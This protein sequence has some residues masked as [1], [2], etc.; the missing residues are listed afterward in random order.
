[1]VPIDCIPLRFTVSYRAARL[2]IFGLQKQASCGWLLIYAN[3]Y[4]LYNLAGK[5]NSTFSS[6]VNRFDGVINR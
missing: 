1:M 4:P 5:S 2:T 3:Y 6:K